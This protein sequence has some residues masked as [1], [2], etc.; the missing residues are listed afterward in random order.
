[1]KELK[2]PRPRRR[3]AAQPEAARLGWF[4]SRKDAEKGSFLKTSNVNSLLL[5]DTE[6]LFLCFRPCLS[7]IHFSFSGY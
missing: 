4:G 1:M 2:S 3:G 6:L 5:V 7:C